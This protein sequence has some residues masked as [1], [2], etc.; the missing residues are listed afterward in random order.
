[1]QVTAAILTE[2][3][4]PG[5]LVLLS[6]IAFLGAVVDAGTGGDFGST[7]TALASKQINTTVII[8]A[9]FACAIFAYFMGMVSNHLMYWCSPMRRDLANINLELA[10]QFRDQINEFRA[11]LGHPG[12]PDTKEVECNKEAASR[13]IDVVFSRMWA[14]VTM[15]SAVADREMMFYRNMA[16]LARASIPAFILL[17][18]TGLLYGG[19]LWVCKGFEWDWTIP[20]LVSVIFLSSLVCLS[21]RLCSTAQRLELSILVNSFLGIAPMVKA[22]GAA[23]H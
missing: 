11:M 15:Q 19:Q 16:R 3:F 2:I 7:I 20:V 17:L 6:V 13:E 9:A 22:K 23:N 8:V 1:M 12:I 21:F 5:A 18:V 4:I 14:F 10:Q